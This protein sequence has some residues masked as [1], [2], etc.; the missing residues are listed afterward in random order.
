MECKSIVVG[1]INDVF[2][3]NNW[4]TGMENQGKGN[5]KVGIGNS[6][7]IIG[8]KNAVKGNDSYVEISQNDI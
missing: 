5:S 4:M 3:D 2:V 8:K 6:N 1:N 7:T